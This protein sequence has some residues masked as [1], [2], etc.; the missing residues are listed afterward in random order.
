[1]VCFAVGYLQLEDAEEAMVLEKDTTMTDETNMRSLLRT[2][3]MSAQKVA[4]VELAISAVQLRLAQLEK[5][6]MCALSVHQ[7]LHT[8]LD[9][10]PILDRFEGSGKG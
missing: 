3:K 9:S 1:M 6:A 10:H 8:T 7:H 2:K 5:Q 4:A